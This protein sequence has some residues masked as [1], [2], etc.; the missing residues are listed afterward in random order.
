M[1][2]TVSSSISNWREKIRARYKLKDYIWWKH[3]NKS[4]VFFGLYNPVDYFKFFLNRGNKTIVWC[5]SDVLQAGWLFRIL[6]IMPK[7]KHICESKVEWGVLSLMLQRSDVMRQ[8]LFFGDPN[9]YPISYK[10]SN[11]PQVFMHINKNAG[12]ES[13]LQTILD[14][15]D[16]VPE[17]TFHIYGRVSEPKVLFNI[18]FHGF[19]P[20]DQFN[21]EIKEYQ[22][23]LRLH[24][25]DG[26]ADTV[27]KSALMGQWPITAIRYPMIS[28]A[29]DKTRLI[30]QLKRLSRRKRPNYKASNYYYK[31]FTK[32][33]W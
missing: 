21:E 29:S 26:F 14:I 22:G 10:F 30:F 16:K 32:S 19:V 15:A 31:V 28:Q 25:F 9:K 12:T 17:V 2:F 7:V 6:Q 23:A 33:L 8:P 5:G 11:N 20:E 1:Y 4:V 13:G 27:A 18:V 24:E 3:W